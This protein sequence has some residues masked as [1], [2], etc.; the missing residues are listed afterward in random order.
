MERREYQGKSITEASPPYLHLH[1][2][3][4]QCTWIVTLQGQTPCSARQGACA[5]AGQC[6]HTRQWHHLT[7]DGETKWCFQLSP[8]YQATMESDRKENYPLTET[9]VS[10]FIITRF[11]ASCAEKCQWGFKIKNIRFEKENK[12]GVEGWLVINA[13]I[14][15]VTQ[16]DS[17]WC[18]F[19]QQY[20][21]KGK[22]WDSK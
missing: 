10:K 16:R 3:L 11:G 15:S 5:T 18:S 1:Q 6:Q 21:W 2:E 4:S 8:R 13:P 9:K 20:L 17:G 7:E 14:D 12:I 19:K 22:P